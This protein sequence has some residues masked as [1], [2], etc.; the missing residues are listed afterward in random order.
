MERLLLGLIFWIFPVSSAHAIWLTNVEGPDIFDDTT[1]HAMVEGT[2][3]S[4]VIHCKSSDPE[5]DIAYV[6]SKKEFDDVPPVPVSLVV[7]VD[8]GPSTKLE[9][10]ARPWND[11]RGAFVASDRSATLSVVKEIG[12]AS[13]SVEIGVKLPGGYRFSDR[14]DAVGSTKAMNS[15]LEGCALKDVSE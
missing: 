6:F 15:V 12:V 4:L 11:K 14:F 9:A 7:R 10:K 5:L 3:G 2:S 1:V 13:S 8:G